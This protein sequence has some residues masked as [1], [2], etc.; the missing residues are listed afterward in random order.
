MCTPSPSAI[1]LIIDQ[2]YTSI[3]NPFA[4]LVPQHNITAATSK[5]FPLPPC[6]DMYSWNFFLTR[7]LDT[8]V[9]HLNSSFWVLP[10]IHGAFLQRKC[11]LFGRQ[12]NLMLIARRSRHF[13][14]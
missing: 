9:G 1:A 3:E 4:P 11:T 12:V 6:K 5:T 7:E 8:C 14:G 2:N 13:A 10:T